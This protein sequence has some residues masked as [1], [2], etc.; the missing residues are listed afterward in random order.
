MTVHEID[1]RPRS[2]N[3]AL[4]TVHDR[5]DDLDRIGRGILPD[6]AGATFHIPGSD[7]TEKFAAY[8][9]STAHVAAG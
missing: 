5:L 7:L 3:L 9:S 4:P 2:E 6:W 8:R 1:G